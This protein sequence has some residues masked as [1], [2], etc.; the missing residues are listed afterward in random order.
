MQSGTPVY[1]WEELLPWHGVG[2]RKDLGGALNVALS[3]ERD[4]YFYCSKCT[5]GWSQIT[6]NLK[7]HIRVQ[8]RGSQWHDLTNSRSDPL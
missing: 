2:L 5:L 7:R 1:K 6:I 3:W 4:V 8:M